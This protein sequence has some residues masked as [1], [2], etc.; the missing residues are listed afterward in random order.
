MLRGAM[1]GAGRLSARDGAVKFFRGVVNE[2][3][4]LL[5]KDFLTERESFSVGARAR[6]EAWDRRDWEG[7]G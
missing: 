6:G 7:G 4:V 3:S 2:S 1:K 5:C